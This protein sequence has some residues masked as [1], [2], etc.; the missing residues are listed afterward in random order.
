MQGERRQKG[1]R[2]TS[3][4]TA[5]DAHLWVDE[6]NHMLPVNQQA[7]HKIFFLYLFLLFPLK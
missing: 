7:S 3:E 6:G 4:L 2:I 1:F 5:V